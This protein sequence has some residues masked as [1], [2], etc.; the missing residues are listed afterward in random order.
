MIGLLDEYKEK[1]DTFDEPEKYLEMV[2][3]SVAKEI[4]MEA[5]E[6]ESASEDV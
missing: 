6:M 3:S 4:N 2:L 5:A 1:K